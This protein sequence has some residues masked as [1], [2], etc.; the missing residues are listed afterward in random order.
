MRNIGYLVPQENDKYD[1][2]RIPRA[3]SDECYGEFLRFTNIVEK[4]QPIGVQYQSINLSFSAFNETIAEL[5]SSYAKANMHSNMVT[6]SLNHVSLVANRVLNVLTAASAFLTSTE[7]RIKKLYGEG[8]NQLK[9]WN[10]LRRDL[11]KNS[12]AYQFMYELR[13][14][15]Q[16]NSLPISRL[17]VKVDKVKNESHFIVQVSKQ[18]LLQSGYDWGKYKK[19][20]ASG[21]DLLDLSPLLEEYVNISKQLFLAFLDLSSEAINDCGKYLDVLAVTFR[22]PKGSIPVIFVDGGEQEN[23]TQSHHVFIPFQNY[24]WLITLK[25]A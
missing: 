9:S 13:N 8:S 7:I 15:S 20:I 12:F 5:T 1:I 18:D 11:H 22:F 2:A 19:L 14:Y 4:L 23:E 24:Q 17:S 6:D 10:N 3:F 16:H 21:N 25:K